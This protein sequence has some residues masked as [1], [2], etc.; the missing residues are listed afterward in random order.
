MGHPLRLIA[1]FMTLPFHAFLGLSLMSSPT[2][3]GG[4]YYESL[5]RDWGPTVLQ[6]QE[7]AGGLLWAAGDFVGI[8]IF[9]VLMIQWA[10]ASDREAVRIDRELDRQ[11]RL[12]ET[13]LK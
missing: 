2:P 3:I 8:L 9:L 6:D 10:K 11:E 7:I 12:S 13:G 5:I 4:G 1:V